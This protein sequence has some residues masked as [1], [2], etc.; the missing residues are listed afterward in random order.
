MVGVRAVRTRVAAPW[1]WPPSRVRRAPPC[2]SRRSRKICRRKFPRAYADGG[3]QS[4]SHSL[5]HPAATTGIRGTRRQRASSDLFAPLKC[6]RNRLRFPPTGRSE[7]AMNRS[8]VAS[9][10]I[11]VDNAHSVS[12]LLLAPASAH[13]CYVLAHGA[14]A[15]M[16]HPFMDVAA[17]ELGERGIATLRYQFPY[18]EQRA[19]RPDP[20]KLA[21]ATVRAAVAEAA[22]LAPALPLVAGGKSFGGRMTSQAQAASPLP[23]VRGLAFLGF[24]LH[25][26]GAAVGRACRASFRGRSPDVVSARGP[27][28]ALGPRV[29][30]AVGGAAGRA[31]LVAAHPRC[32]SFLPRAGPHR[33]QARRRHTR[34]DGCACRLDPVGDL[35]ARLNAASCLGR[36]E[37][38]RGA[39]ARLRRLDLAIARRRGGHE[40]VEQFVRRLRHLLHRAIEGALVCLGRP[41]ESAQLADELQGGRANF[42]VRGGRFEVVQRLNV[43][44]HETSSIRRVVLRYDRR[45]AIS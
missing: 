26:A 5:R 31:R 44:A 24:P 35:P 19:R 9:V 11:T 40:G 32:R 34:H 25:P 42:F 21:Q 33:T 22:R 28:Q 7:R 14:G 15:G 2:R 30:S 17:R 13:A 36:A 18:M 41:R 29:A 10:T 38:V 6:R 39:L 45:A 27:R 37:A 43:S 3:F 1:P 16:L 8:D 23:G 20:P 12:G 4:L